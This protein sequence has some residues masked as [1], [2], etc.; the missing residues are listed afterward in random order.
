MTGTKINFYDEVKV[1]DAENPYF[2]KLGAVVG[3]SEEDGFIYGYAVLFHGEDQNVFV[4]S[5][6]IISTGVCFT[7]DDYY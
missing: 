7:R 3:I 4:K 1:V 5:E 6:S 2:N